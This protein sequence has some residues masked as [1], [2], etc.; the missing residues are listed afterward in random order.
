MLSSTGNK[1]IAANAAIVF[2]LLNDWE[3]LFNEDELVHLVLGVASPVIGKSKLP[4]GSRP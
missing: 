4:L 3:P 2:L 1:G